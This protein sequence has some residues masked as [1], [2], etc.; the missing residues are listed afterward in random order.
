HCRYSQS[1]RSAAEHVAWRRW[2]DNNARG[3]DQGSSEAVA[4]ALVLPRAEGQDAT[5][6]IKER[7]GINQ[8]G[9]VAKNRSLPADASA[10]EVS[11]AQTGEAFS[12]RGAEQPFE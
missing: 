4:E 9:E 6:Q 5:Q 12:K 7:Q 2:A 11:H 10:L 1:D 8:A 3:N